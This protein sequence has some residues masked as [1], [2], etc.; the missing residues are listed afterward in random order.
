MLD[1]R[2]PARPLPATGPSRRRPV[3]LATLAVRFEEEA[4]RV[5]TESAREAG[6]PLLVVDLFRLPLCAPAAIQLQAELE[7][8]H[9]TAA[10]AATGGVPTE[11]LM[12]VAPLGTTRALVRLARE[13]DAGLVVFGP[14]RRR[15]G[16]RRVRATARALCADLDC[17]VWVGPA[18]P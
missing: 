7:A 18:T 1:D 2:L 6:V 15:A 8:V 12:L 10:R 16:R 4:E 14:E 5:A 9:R 13:R 11:V 17:L 3:I